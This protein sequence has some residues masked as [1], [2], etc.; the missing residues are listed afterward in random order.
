MTL[1][2]SVFA[3]LVAVFCWLAAP[4]FAG[5]SV[6]QDTSYSLDEVQDSVRGIV[7]VLEREDRS[8]LHIPAILATLPEDSRTLVAWADALAPAFASLSARPG[9][10]QSSY[11]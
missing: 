10:L 3:L 8:I 7:A 9:R 5:L 1:R 11:G 4:A 6:D 2:Q